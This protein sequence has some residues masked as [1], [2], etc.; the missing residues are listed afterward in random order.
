MQWLR[1]SLPAPGDG[2]PDWEIL[3]LIDKTEN[4]YVDLNDLMK[5]LGKQFP[6]YS[7]ISLFKL[8]EQGISLSK[9]AKE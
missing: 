5:G 2:R 3:N 1:P 6:S 7:D 8:G 9:R 4:R